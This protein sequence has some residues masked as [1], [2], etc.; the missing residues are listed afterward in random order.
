MPSLK[1]WQTDLIASP[2]PA[3]PLEPESGS[4][5]S[6]FSLLLF[7]GVDLCFD[8]FSTRRIDLYLDLDLA[9]VVSRETKG[10]VDH[11]CFRCVH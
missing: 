8:S 1:L 7:F 5:V 3:T 2:T 10:F 9:Y 6:L 11:P 4:S